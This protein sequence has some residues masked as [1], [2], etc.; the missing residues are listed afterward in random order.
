M[1]KKAVHR[2]NLQLELLGHVQEQQDVSH[3]TAT[4]LAELKFHQDETANAGKDE[5]QAEED[6][7]IV[8]AHLQRLGFSVEI[9]SSEGI[10]LLDVPPY[11]DD[12]SDEFEAGSCSG[13]DGAKGNRVSTNASNTSL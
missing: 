10:P 13:S 3:D 2:C 9:T 4:L 6:V 12:L 8:R 5:A 1:A 11:C 7:G